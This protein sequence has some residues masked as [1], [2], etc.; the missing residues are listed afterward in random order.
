MIPAIESKR[1]TPSQ[2]FKNRV[3]TCKPYPRGIRKKIL[4]LFP[5]FNTK[6]GIK[7]IDNVLTGT[8]SDVEL[9]TII[10]TICKS[11]KPQ[12]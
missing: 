3:L 9:T 2:H 10:E 8:T 4:E 12:H 7:L 11:Q 1:E 6:K 5:K